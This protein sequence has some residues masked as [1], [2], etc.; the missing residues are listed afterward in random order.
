[1]TCNRSSKT[2]SREPHD[3]SEGLVS[4]GT[5]RLIFSREFCRPSHRPFLGREPHAMYSWVAGQLNYCPGPR[6]LL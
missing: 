1:M 3:H 4:R 6:V 2:D 5:G